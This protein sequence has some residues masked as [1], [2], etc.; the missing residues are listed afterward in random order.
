MG[1]IYLNKLSEKSA[2]WLSARQLTVASNIAN[3]DT[4]GF[5]ALNV[6]EMGKVGS[7]FDTLVR[8]HT[9][10]MS[11]AAGSASGVETYQEEAWEVDHAG[12]SV[13]LPREMLKIS[14]ISTAYKL[15]TSVMKSFHRMVISVFGS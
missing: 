1:E 4:P 10:H 7:G 3:A 13:S 9:N 2:N 14:E 8:T 15:N 11:S 6:K 12:G 5:K